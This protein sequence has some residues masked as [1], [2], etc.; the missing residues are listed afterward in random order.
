MC[1]RFYLDADAEFLLNYYR[2]QYEP[3]VI[4]EHPIIYPTQNSPVII[5]SNGER[6]IGMMQWG[7][8]IPGASKPIINSRAESIHEK[9]LFKEA[10]EKRRCIVPA[11]GFFEWSDLTQQKPKPKYQVTVKDEPLMSMAGIYT[12]SVAEDGQIS[13]LFTIVTREANEDMKVIHPR[14]PL[15]L[16]NDALSA[17]LDIKTPLSQ[18]DELLKTDI[19]KLNLIREQNQ[20]EFDI[21]TF[22]K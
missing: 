22:L 4:V 21:D 10:Y 6:R 8:K 20:M 2:I 7:F 18:I 17:W 13:W 19:G 15:I 12:K 3:R 5:D 9:R 1:G 16:G 14:M 11:S